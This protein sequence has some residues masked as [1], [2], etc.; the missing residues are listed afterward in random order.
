MG[1][2]AASKDYRFYGAVRRLDGRTHRTQAHWG[3]A[4]RGHDH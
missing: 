3:E 4:N 1:V 2:F